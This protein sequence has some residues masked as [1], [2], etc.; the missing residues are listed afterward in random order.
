MS[1]QK[2]QR[3]YTNCTKLAGAALSAQ[4]ILGMIK[5]D[6]KIRSGILGVND[7][8]EI[9]SSQFSTAQL[10]TT[11]VSSSMN[12]AN[13]AN[14]TGIVAFDVIDGNIFVSDSKFIRKLNSI[15]DSAGLTLIDI[16][17]FGT[18]DWMSLRQ[19]NRI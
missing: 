14:A 7:K 12:E 19:Q 10:K 2:M 17:L 11:T 6:L 13:L 16:M 9:V 18:D 3:D 1:S 4:A 5:K 15:C 8:L